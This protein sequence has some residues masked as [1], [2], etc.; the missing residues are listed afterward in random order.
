[1]GEGFQG[2]GS[3]MM[4]TDVV[5]GIPQAGWGMHG[6]RGDR[7]YGPFSQSMMGGFVPYFIWRSVMWII[8]LGVIGVVIWLVVRMQKQRGSLG[9]SQG[10]SPLEIAKRRYARGEISREEFETLKRDLQ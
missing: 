10:D 1:M 7:G 9:G 8:L 5:W 2:P 6:R 4:A 3:S